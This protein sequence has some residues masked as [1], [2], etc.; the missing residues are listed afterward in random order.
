MSLRWNSCLGVH[1]VILHSSTQTSFQISYQFEASA[2][3][4]AAAA[5]EAVP[6]ATAWAALDEPLKH[7]KHRRN[8]TTSVRSIESQ[9]EDRLW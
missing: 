5:A 8:T 1:R 3:A 2:K 7:K 9:D 4:A 6:A